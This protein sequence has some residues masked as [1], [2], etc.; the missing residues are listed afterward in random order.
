MNWFSRIF[1][2]TPPSTQNPPLSVER[3]LPMPKHYVFNETGNILLSCTEESRKDFGS[4]ISDIFTD[5][6]VF[7]AAMTQAMALTE[8][9]A[10]GKPFSVYNY[11]AIRSIL[12]Q[13][14]MF[15]ETN[16]QEM[17]FASKRVGDDL[18]KDF[19]EQVLGRQF[20]GNKLPFTRAMFNGMKYQAKD[21]RG[22]ILS[23]ASK[24]ATQQNGSL[25][26]VCEVLMGIPQVSAI[27]V[28]LEPFSD[29]DRDSQVNQEKSFETKSQNF[30][31]LEKID[32]TSHSSAGIQRHWR[33]KKRSYLFI[34]PRLL[35]GNAAQLQ[36]AGEQNM[37]EL[38]LDLANQLKQGL[39]EETLK[40]IP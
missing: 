8:N 35:S 19:V 36:A 14:G 21:K 13:S 37:K 5:I 7:F 28:K 27:L 23:D 2:R 15:V 18:G 32:S 25:F 12:G 34:P 31:G 22:Q 39:E 30:Y 3:D 33:Y 29:G 10:T 16:V 17:E 1:C 40:E 24:L 4:N 26:F 20:G 11:R 38:V 9:P 6:S